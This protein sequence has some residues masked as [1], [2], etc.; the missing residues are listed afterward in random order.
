MSQQVIYVDG[1][2]A[3]YPGV[4]VGPLSD[5]QKAYVDEAGKEHPGR[6]TIVQGFTELTDEVGQRIRKP[7]QI[8]R[9][10]FAAPGN[11]PRY[12]DVSARLKAD[13]MKVHRKGYYELAPKPAE[14]EAPKHAPHA[15]HEHDKKK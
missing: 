2:G 12:A 5:I 1:T 9:V 10:N 6:A 14:E 7:Y 3:R 11:K 8:I 4:I 13:L 15:H